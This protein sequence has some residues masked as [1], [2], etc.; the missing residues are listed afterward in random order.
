MVTSLAPSRLLP[1]ILIL[2]SLFFDG[3]DARAANFYYFNPD[4]A[5]GNL[6]RL[7]TEMD[8]ILE[9]NNL[10]LSFQPFARLRDFD[11]EVKA[12]N[13]AVLFL[14]AWYLH[15]EGKKLGLQPILQ[16]IRHGKKNYTKV[17]LVSK[18]TIWQAND[19]AN[20]TI[21]MTSMGQAGNHILNEQLFKHFNLDSNDLSIVTTSKDIDA[22]FALALQQVDAA[23]VAETNLEHVKRI[24]PHIAQQI[25]I[26]ARSGPIAMPLLCVK[27]GTDSASINRLKRVFINQRPQATKLLEMLQIDDWQD[28]TK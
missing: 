12:E 7:K 4:S 14:P 25:K 15:S 10:L 11:R 19:L 23:L 24:N 21:A 1:L 28:L 18:Q 6:G 27:K 16:P 3:H 26:I 13:P 5:Q 22:L 2:I 8:G 9:K 20:K 17:L